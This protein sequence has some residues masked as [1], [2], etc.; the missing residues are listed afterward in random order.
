[1][2]KTR[3]YLT[4][5][6]SGKDKEE[7]HYSILATVISVIGYL[8]IIS[9]IIIGGYMLFSS[10]GIDLFVFFLLII[11]SLVLGIII[12]GFSRIIYLLN[13]INNSLKDKKNY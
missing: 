11:S 3:V 8:F 4:E 5:S 7:E 1:M 13:E 6:L 2:D 9:G 12:I 10:K